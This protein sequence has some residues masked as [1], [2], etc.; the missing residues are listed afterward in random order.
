[1]TARVDATVEEVARLMIEKGLGAVPVV[2]V[3]GRLWGIVTESDFAGREVVLWTSRY[4]TEHR[5]PKL[6]GE[7]IL[8]D[9]LEQVYQAARGRSV[10]EI[11]TSP[12]LAAVESEPVQ[13]AL[14][15]MLQNGVGH[16]PVVRHGVPVGMLA[17]H[18]LL[19]LAARIWESGD[20]KPVGEAG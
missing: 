20:E 15:R 3:D 9:T 6:F 7:V 16:L 11:M 13:Q 5:A 10:G 2:G 18:D 17:R 1:V 8:G 12:V 4:G 19:L 14:E